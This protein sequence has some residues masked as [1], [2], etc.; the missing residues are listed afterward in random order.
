MYIEIDHNYLS[1]ISFYLC[2]NY[3]GVKKMKCKMFLKS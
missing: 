3:G 1:E 2:F